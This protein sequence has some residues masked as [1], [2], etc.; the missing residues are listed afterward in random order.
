MLFS[1]HI[2]EAE[3][4]EKKALGYSVTHKSRAP[5][6]SPPSSFTT[7]NNACSRYHKKKYQV[8]VVGDSLLKVIEAPLCQ[9]G[10]KS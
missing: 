6:Q 10:D 3:S 4:T 1:N 2:P 7:K 5:I 9:P 8:L